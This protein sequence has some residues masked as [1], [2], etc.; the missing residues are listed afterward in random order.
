MPRRRRAEPRE[1]T[2]TVLLDAGAELLRE[3]PVGNLFSQVKAPTI[4][5]RANLTP[6]AFYYHWGTQDEYVQELLDHCLVDERV[7]AGEKSR[8]RVA[9]LEAEGA[10]FDQ[11]ALE[12]GRLDL[13]ATTE[14]PMLRVQMALWAKHGQDPRMAQLLR[15]LYTS[16]DA[17]RSPVYERL[18]A[19]S[20]L[21]PRKP[22]TLD[23]ITVVLDA[24]LDGLALRR[25][26]D[27]D[28]VPAAL[29][30]SVTQALIPA[31]TAPAGG[32]E[33]EPARP[34]KAGAQESARPRA[35]RKPVASA[36]GR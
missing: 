28:S 35:R 26:T 2:Q 34:A 32:G 15:K 16:L 3:Q 19:D 25:A 23:Q 1:D 10:S 22:F 9:E 33:T 7:A 11:I 21:E 24:L 36:A 29:F 31:M 18:L 12:A 4:A 27:P 5:R 8:E 14:D 20:G 13:E 6:G 30:G 17:A